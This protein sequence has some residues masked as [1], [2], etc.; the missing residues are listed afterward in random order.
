MSKYGNITRNGYD[1]LLEVEFEAY[2]NLISKTKGTKVISTERQVPF[3]IIV[4]NNSIA[5]YTADFVVSMTS[6]EKLI[7]ETKGFMSS[8]TAFRY[9]VLC[10]QL[11]QGYKFYIVKKIKRTF[12]FFEYSNKYKYLRLIPADNPL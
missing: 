10:S 1:S 7:L 4:N 12:E 5:R 8:E 2:V 3:D 6:G 9:K 11:T